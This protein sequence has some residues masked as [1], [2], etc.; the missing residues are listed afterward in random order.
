[1][2]TVSVIVPVY[3][4][5]K[6]IRHTIHSVQEQTFTDWELI[7]VIDGSP[8]N[9]AK[10]CKE[11]AVN[12]KRISVLE[13]ENQGVNKARLNGLH[14]CTAS[15]VTFL[16]SDDSLPPYALEVMF[17]EIKK[18]YDVVKG[19]VA[20]NATPERK[21]DYHTTSLDQQQFLEQIYLGDIEP[22]MCGSIYRKDLL[23]DYIFQLC[24]DN[25][26]LI[27]EDWITN[28]YIAKRIN[29][30]LIIDIP[31][32]NYFSNENSTMNTFTISEEYGHR[33]DKIVNGIIG[34]NPQWDYMKLLK[35]AT[36]VSNFFNPSRSFSLEVY[37]AFKIYVAIYGIESLY[38]YVDKRFLWFSEYEF[39]YRIYSWCYRK[40]KK[41]RKKELKAIK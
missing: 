19:V 40:A 7:L 10:I 39:F 2:A 13:Q 29:K 9:S 16:D 25:R 34:N 14:H 41:I 37:Q 4:A 31:V 38:Q 33:I 30:V 12:D 1:M 28:L 6:F 5:E 20:I 23:D 35:K 15:F 32:Y 22:Y 11:L 17:T 3:K 24:I 21:K 8:D 18:G 36:C 26:L 27:G